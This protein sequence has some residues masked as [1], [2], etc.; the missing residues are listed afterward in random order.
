MEKINNIIDRDINELKSKTTEAYE[1]LRQNKVY[2][3]SEIISKSIDIKNKHLRKYTELQKKFK[4]DNKFVENEYKRYTDE[5]RDFLQKY[6]PYGEEKRNI[7]DINLYDL[8]KDYQY[9]D[10]ILQNESDYTTY[11]KCSCDLRLMESLFSQFIIN[12]HLNN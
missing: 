5:Q 6:M 7:I 3:Q 2:Q 1:K 4:N 8:Q 10:N 12:A 11:Q 9:I